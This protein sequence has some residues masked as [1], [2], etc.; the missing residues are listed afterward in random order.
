MRALLIAGM[1]AVAVG[2]GGGEGGNDT[3][4]A[5]DWTAKVEQMC[6]QQAN[7]SERKV[8]ELQ[9]DS[10]SEEEFAAKVLEYG[11]DSTQPVIDKVAD[12]PAPEGKEQRAKDFV[13]SMNRLLP[14]LDDLADTVR[15]KDEAK[16]KEVTSKMQAET[17]KARA[18]AR[19]LGI[20]ACIPDN[21]AS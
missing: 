16:L 19:D 2:C 17:A 12:M 15:S 20:D 13:A 1:A 8:A 9:K 14:M 18:A 6:R 21:D 7:D 3:I 11:A 10:A 4:A 5:S